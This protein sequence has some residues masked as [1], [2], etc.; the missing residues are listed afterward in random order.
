[1]PIPSDTL[2]LS[3]LSDPPRLQGKG[4]SKPPLMLIADYDFYDISD[5]LNEEQLGEYRRDIKIDEAKARLR[6]FFEDRCENVF[7]MQQLEVF[8]EKEFFHWITGKAVNELVATGFLHAEEVPLLGFT[9]VKFVFHHKH[10]YYKRQ[11]KRCIE[12]IRQYSDPNIAIA[13]GRQAEVL[14]FNALVNRGFLSRGQDTNEYRGKRWTWTE[15]RLDFIIEK[16]GVAYGTE[17][18]N[19]LGYIPREELEVKL[20]M[21][22]CLRLKPLFIMRASPK[23]YNHKVIKRGGYAM[24]FE[25]QVYP[26]GQDGLVR[27][28]RNILGLPVDCPRAIPEGIIDRFMRWH[29][30]TKNM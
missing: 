8:F 29:E 27:R 7:Y 25:V 15:H 23:D 9:R 22:D 1:M 16:D 28:I 26:F 12:V 13:C 2:Q 5:L 10:R 11:I 20:D 19:T 18:K 3:Q 14:F 6:K 17:V 4:K 21:C 24:I 30:K